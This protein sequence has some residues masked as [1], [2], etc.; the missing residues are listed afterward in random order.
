M[1]VHPPCPNCTV[2]AHCEG[3]NY[4]SIC[5]CNSSYVGCNAYGKQSCLYH[6]KTCFFSTSNLSECATNSDCPDDLA[7]GEDEECVD[8]PCECADN[9]YCEAASNHTAGICICKAG[10]EGDPHL[11]GCTTDIGKFYG[12]THY[13]LFLLCSLTKNWSHPHSSFSAICFL[14]IVN[15]DTLSN[16]RIHIL[17]FRSL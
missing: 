1:C 6:S 2:N 9:A 16:F 4:I 15:L 8:P 3:R 7:C 10:F 17:F 14:G 13:S 5:T 11:G 12:L